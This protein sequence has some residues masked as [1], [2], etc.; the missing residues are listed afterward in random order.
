[1]QLLKMMVEKGLPVPDTVINQ[2]LSSKAKP[3]PTGARVT[4]TR[5][6]NAYGFTVAGVLLLA[7][8]LITHD[9]NNVSVLAPGL[10]FLC[11]G[12]GGLA[13]I[14]LRNNLKRLRTHDNFGWRTRQAG[15]HSE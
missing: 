13:G 14:Y 2:I 5:T 15:S 8:P 4:Y 3:E 11:L 12:L 6:R 1:M 10:L 7:Y 9:W